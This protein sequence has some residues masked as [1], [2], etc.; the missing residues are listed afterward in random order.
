MAV[1]CEL[2][3]MFFKWKKITLVMSDPERDVQITPATQDGWEEEY[4]KW[5]RIVEK[6]DG[7]AIKLRT[8]AR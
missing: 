2:A 1:E 5:H 4:R 7:V 6:L 8:S 3:S